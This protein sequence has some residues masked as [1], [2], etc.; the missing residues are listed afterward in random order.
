MVTLQRQAGNRAVADL[1]AQRAPGGG[2]GRGGRRRPA[3]QDPWTTLTDT[4][5]QGIMEAL[6]RIFDTSR[7]VDPNMAR[8]LQPYGGHLWN[9]YLSY[10]GDTAGMFPGSQRLEVYDRAVAGLQP[11]I[12]RYLVDQAGREWYDNRL[13]GRLERGRWDVQ[14]GIASKR[15]EGEVAAGRANHTSRENTSFDSRRPRVVSRTRGPGPS[16]GSTRPAPSAQPRWGAMGPVSASSRPRPSSRRSARIVA[17]AAAVLSSTAS[18][19]P[20]GSDG[21]PGVAASSAPR[22]AS[23]LAAFQRRMRP[24][25][26]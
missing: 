4:W 26:A 21:V 7:R 5:V 9:L 10:R 13:R 12:D 20:G 14:F 25:N 2:R 18:A 23:S 8:Y 1:V 11:V 16:N 15:V 19:P 24:S 3:F 6:D 17:S 22:Y